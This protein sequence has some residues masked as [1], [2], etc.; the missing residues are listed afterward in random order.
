ML[1]E[2]GCERRNLLVKSHRLGIQWVRLVGDRGEQAKSVAP[3]ECSPRGLEETTREVSG[4]QLG[5]VPVD[6]RLA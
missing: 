3:E 2:L 6:E 1:G 4:G 5:G